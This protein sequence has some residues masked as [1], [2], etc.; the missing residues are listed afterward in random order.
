MLLMA[1]LQC[2]VVAQL[3]ID[4]ALL[5]AVKLETSR[6]AA[7]CAGVVLAALHY[8]RA[9]CSWGQVASQHT[10]GSVRCLHA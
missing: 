5:R 8:L 10:R 1:S 3:Q 2:G 6:E 9:S 7:C 4:C